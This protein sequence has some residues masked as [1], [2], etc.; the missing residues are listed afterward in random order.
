MSR[1]SR[2]R[3][4]VIGRIVQVCV[5]ADFDFDLL[6]RAFADQDVVLAS[7]VFLDVGREFVTGDA[8]VFVSNDATEGDDRDFEVPPMSMIMLPIGS[9]TSMPMPM[10]AAMGS[11]IRPSFPPA[12]SALS[13][14]ARFSTSVMP[15]GMQMTMRSEGLNQDFRLL[16]ILIMPAPVISSAEVRNPPSF[17]AW[18]YFCGSSCIC[19]A[20]RPMADTFEPRSLAGVLGSSA[21]CL[22][23][24]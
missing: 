16:I 4:T 7:H 2:P 8:D 3:R 18:L 11:W 15:D 13:P 21:T 6:C 14:T 22:R 9:S 12:C 5:A 19:C 20:K 23:S 17:E 1:K 24:R 10:A